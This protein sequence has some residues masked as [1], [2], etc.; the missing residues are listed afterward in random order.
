[1]CLLW[2]ITYGEFSEFIQEKK[3]HI[4]YTL[5]IDFN[6]LFVLRYLVGVGR[7]DIFAARSGRGPAFIGLCGLPIFD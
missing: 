2:K 6:I 3:V 1:M 7:S 5:H 4:M